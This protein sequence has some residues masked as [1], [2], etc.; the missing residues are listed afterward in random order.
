MQ[1]YF[2]FCFL[3]CLFQQ[4]SDSSSNVL[5]HRKTVESSLGVSPHK[6]TLAAVLKPGGKIKVKVA[7]KPK[8]DIPRSSLIIIRS[9]VYA[10][11]YGYEGSL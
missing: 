7:F 5:R 1:L 2:L 6:Q 10:D 9:V 3:F 11:N 4:K 8:D